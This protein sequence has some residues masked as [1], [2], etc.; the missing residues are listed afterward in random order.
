MDLKPMISIDSV[1]TKE[2][3]FV[4]LKQKLKMED[5]PIYLDGILISSGH[6]M[7]DGKQALEIHFYFY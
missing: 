2:T 4:F 1:I 6:Q 7:K 5:R 3:L